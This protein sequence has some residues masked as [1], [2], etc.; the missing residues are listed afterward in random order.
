MVNGRLK[1]DPLF[2]GLTRPTMIFG[3]SLQYAMLNLAL[4]SVFFIQTESM[5]VLILSAFIHAIGY[6]IYF[7]EP[8]FLEI[9]MLRNQYFANCPNRLFYGANSYMV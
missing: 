4:A 8:R 3:V 9:Y 1:T 6:V 2:L 5:K 7:H